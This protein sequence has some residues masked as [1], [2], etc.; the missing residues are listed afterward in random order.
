MDE[1]SDL[2]L[3][4]TSA[5]K[6]DHLF[7]VV[8]PPGGLGREYTYREIAER[9]GAAGHPISHSQVHSLRTKPE[10]VIT[11]KAIESLAAGFDVSVAYFFNDATAAKIERDLP[12]LAA[13]RDPNIRRLARHAEGLSEE[14]IG[15][16]EQL[17]DRAREW[18][19]L[20]TWS[21]DEQS[22]R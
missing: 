13:L 22:S 16:I 6:L 8:K 3:H 9:A 14:S 19:G 4:R 21:D 5:E 20:G 2:P 7:K 15:S 10:K 11:L 12:L 17:V 18:E 1:P